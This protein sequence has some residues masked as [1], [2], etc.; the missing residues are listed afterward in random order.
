MTVTA[1]KKIIYAGDDLILNLVWKSGTRKEPGTPINIT[2][3]TF[4]ATIVRSGAI[5]VSGT[6]TLV[7]A[8]GKI[9]VAF[10]ET[11]TQNLSGSYEV[12]LRVTDTLGDTSMFMVMPLEVKV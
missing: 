12:R 4:V 1:S 3:Y 8:E 7:E 5:V 6:V 9:K 10:S 2:G 11:Q